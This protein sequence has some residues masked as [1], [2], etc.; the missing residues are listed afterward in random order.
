M[1]DRNVQAIRRLNGL[2]NAGR[3]V[4]AVKLFHPDAEFRDL[5]HAPDTAEVLRGVDAILAAFEQWTQVFDEFEAE[6][7]EYVDA[8]PWV[9]CDTRWR[10]RGRGS[11]AGVDIRQADAYELDDGQV[12][13]AVLGYATVATAREAVRR[14]R[15]ND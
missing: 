2:V 6:V 3:G 7:Y 11:T 9:I 15:V 1:S 12:T 8:D 10:G 4:E 13:R 5:A 14:A